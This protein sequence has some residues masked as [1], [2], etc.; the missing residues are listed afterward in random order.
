[1]EYTNEYTCS[2]C[3]LQWVDIGEQNEPETCPHCEERNNIPHTS[4]PRQ[5]PDLEIS[6]VLTLCTSHITKGDNDLM[7]AK[8]MA[9]PVVYYD[10]E[11]GWWIYVNKNPQPVKNFV[12][13]GL[14]GALPTL[15]EFAR[16]HDCQWI[17]LDRDA[18]PI[19]ALPTYEW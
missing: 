10:F 4:T 18:D 13:R 5:V 1:M 8:P 12:G 9:G 11:Y 14:S 7:I 19:D 15:L 2:D 17:K 3:E 6:K 16:A